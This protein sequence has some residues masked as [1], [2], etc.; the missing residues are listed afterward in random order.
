MNGAIAHDPSANVPHVSRARDG[1]LRLREPLPLQHGGSLA[2]AAIAWELH[3]HAGPVVIALGGISAGRHVAAHA[4]NPAPGWWQPF[5][6]PG[7]ALDTRRFRVLSIDWLGGPGGSSAPRAGRA[8]P[9]IG[10]RDQAAAV[11]RV[12]DHIGAR[13][14]LAFVGASYGG[15]VALAFAEDWPDRAE[16]IVAIGAAHRAHPMATAVRTVQ[17]GIVRLGL[18]TGRPHD[19]L[20]IARALAMT[21]YRTAEEF[22][23]RFDHAGG[24]EDGRARFP[25]EPYL[26][27]CGA[28][29]AERFTPDSFLRL[30]ESIDLHDVTP[31]RIRTPTTVVSV[32]GDAIVPSWQASELVR[33]HGGRCRH[34]EIESV[35]GHDAFLKEVDVLSTVLRDA[36][37]ED[38]RCA[39]AEGGA[40]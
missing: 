23:T 29:F 22:D 7:R 2:E 8:F 17:R 34:V 33:R 12:L 4:A 35:Y 40:A 25:V 6:G 19:A 21:T 24:V 10:T 20:R 39:R 5:V 13:R 32:R 36:L 28:A 31:E 38:L 37:D 14:A 26:E 3:G 9:S 11:I 1:V 30:S 15:M 18:E 16:R 27:R